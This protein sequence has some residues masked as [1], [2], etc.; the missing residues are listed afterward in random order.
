MDAAP[1]PVGWADVATTYDVDTRFD[2]VDQK[3][4][5]LMVA[6]VGVVVAAARL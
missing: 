2:I 1:P 4:M 6:M 5:T 3:M